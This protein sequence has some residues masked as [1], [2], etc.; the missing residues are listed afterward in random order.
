MSDPS[1]IEKRHSLPLQV[2][3]GRVPSTTNVSHED[4]YHNHRLEKVS[5]IVFKSANWKIS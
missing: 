3:P 4:Q 1:D 2:K 5:M